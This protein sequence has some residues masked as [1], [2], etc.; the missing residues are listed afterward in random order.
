MIYLL[1]QA[2]L[3]LGIILMKSYWTTALD[4]C[5]W[6]LC[7]FSKCTWVVESARVRLMQ[8]CMKL[9]SIAAKLFVWCLRLRVQHG[10]PVADNGCSKSKI[11][12][13]LQKFGDRVRYW[14]LRWQRHSLQRQM[15]YQYE[16]MNKLRASFSRCLNAVKNVF[17]HSFYRSMY[18]SYYWCDFRKAYIPW[19][20]AAFN[21]GVAGLCTTCCGERVLEV[22]EFSV[23]FLPLTPYWKNV[24]LFLE[25]CRV[26]HVWLRA[27]LQSDC[28]IRVLVLIIST[29]QPYFTLWLSAQT[30][31]C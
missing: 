18:A 22:I 27:L 20:R 21:F 30:L 8:D 23:T 13:L 25:W 26:Q 6:H 10:H 5:W 2:T 31:Q 7:V 12:F 14:A 28:V 24:Y 29:L 1:N 3:K 11:C 17:I 15:Q 9:F 19:L 16:A 4:D